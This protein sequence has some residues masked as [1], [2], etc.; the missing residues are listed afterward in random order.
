[1][2]QPVLVRD[3]A[4]LN[5]PAVSSDGASTKKTVKA[6]LVSRLALMLRYENLARV[7]TK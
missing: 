5:R 2:V 6:K 7:K 3:V 4:L 1:M